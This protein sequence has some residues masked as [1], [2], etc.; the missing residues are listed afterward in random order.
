MNGIEKNWKSLKEKKS[1]KFM[2]RTDAYVSFHFFF[3]LKLC[4]GVNN[5]REGNHIKHKFVAHML[6][7]YTWVKSGHKELIMENENMD[8]G[9]LRWPSGMYTVM[10]TNVMHC[11]SLLEYGNTFSILFRLSKTKS[12]FV[13]LLLH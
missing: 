1:F 2:T 7:Y 12:V 3:L 13:L 10:H 6:G 9:F 5:Q 11:S 8:Q 4:K